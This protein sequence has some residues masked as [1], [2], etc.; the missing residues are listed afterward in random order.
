MTGVAGSYDGRQ[1]Y[2]FADIVPVVTGA[3]GALSWAATGLPG[4]MIQDPASG[5][6]TGVPGTYGS[7]PS[8][9]TVKDATDDASV[10]LK[11]TFTLA[12][13]LAVTN[14]ASRMV[15]RNGLDFVG[16]LPASSASAARRR[17]AASGPSRVGHRQ[18]DDRRRHRKADG[19]VLHPG[20]KI[21]V[22]DSTDK[23]T[24]SS[25]AFTLDVM[26]PVGIAGLP[27]SIVARYGFDFSAA[28]PSLLNGVGSVAWTW[29]AGVTPPKWLVI[30]PATGVISGVAKDM[31][32]A[33]VGT[34]TN[35]RVTATDSTQAAANSVSIAVSMYAQAKVTVTAQNIRNRV[36]D[37]VTITP[38]QTGVVGTPTWSL[39][40]TSGT[41]PAGLVADPATGK[42]NARVTDVGTASFVL[43]VKDSL[44][45]R[46]FDSDAFSIVTK[47]AFAISGL[48]SD[49]RVRVGNYRETDAPV[50]AGA[51]S[52]VRYAL[53]IAVP[54]GMSFDTTTGILKGLPTVQASYPTVTLTATDPTVGDNRT[55]TATFALN[56][57]GP[58]T[59]SGTTDFSVRGGADVAARSFKPT[60]V[61]SID[62]T[63]VTWQ[64]AA[65]TLP[66]GVTV[67]PIT[68][69][70]AGTAPAVASPATYPG[71]KLV[72]V[73]ADQSQSPASA[74]FALTVNP[75]L[76][77]TI[78]DQSL[79]EG[80]T[81]SFSAAPTGKVG[82]LT[83]AVTGLPTGLSLNTST[84]TVSGT[85]PAPGAN[86]RTP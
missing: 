23:V 37:T 6:V 9:L 81:A 42:V 19:A 83:W 72:A 74:A 11:P 71:L 67:D 32:Q 51:Q 26:E 46:S 45:G 28:A 64:L 56:V 16:K 49:Y 18:P 25:D 27:T 22:Q 40:A 60:A 2:A 12:R 62:P 21:Q 85:P 57:L 4:G 36:G 75:T 48:L 61:N 10:D 77:F 7:F 63:K 34:T 3:K 39:V 69:K 47:P 41:L 30:D 82:T 35:V 43:R 5:K 52:P 59:V 70:L 14:V 78:A 44:D 84:G 31:D 53:S 17:G 79:S 50:V 66:A 20:L 55:S 1:G 33:S 65:G 8:V 38:Q 13:P 58:M 76:D 73:D 86:S 24:A 15:A 68:G 54:N 80:V 29:A